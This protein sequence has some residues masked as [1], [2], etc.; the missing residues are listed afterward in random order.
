MRTLEGKISLYVSEEGAELEIHCASSGCLIAK[1]KLSSETFCSILGRL[2]YVTCS[3]NVLD[4][5]NIHLIG[6]NEKIES[7]EFKLPEGTNYQNRKEI[8]YSEALKC[9]PDGWE[10]DEYFNSQGNFFKKDG[11]EWA[12]CTIR[13]WE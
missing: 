3:V 2:S 11:E 13:K 5:E 6:K 9:V 7:F 1:T 10:P 4:S 8:A 12:R